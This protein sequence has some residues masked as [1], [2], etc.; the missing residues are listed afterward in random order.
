MVHPVVLRTAATIR[1]WSGLPLAPRRATRDD[2]DSVPDIRWFWGTTCGSCAVLGDCAQHLSL[3]D[4]SVNYE[5]TTEL[6]KDYV[7]VD[8]HC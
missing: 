8:I 3:I 1:Q 7:D 4:R 5:N 2:E 6:L